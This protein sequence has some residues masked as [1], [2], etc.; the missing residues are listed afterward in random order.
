MFIYKYGYLI[1]L[2]N[3]ETNFTL[4]IF[5]CLYFGIN[6]S[7]Q[8]VVTH[9]NV[10]FLSNKGYRVWRRPL[11]YDLPLLRTSHAANWKTVRCASANSVSE[12]TVWCHTSTETLRKMQLSFFLES[13]KLI[14]IATQLYARIPH[15]QCRISC[16]SS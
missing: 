6:S 9:G 3:Y 11:T 15:I 13:G 7:F 12:D 2:C 8:R 4:L 10:V 5:Y 16:L 14:Q 1:Q